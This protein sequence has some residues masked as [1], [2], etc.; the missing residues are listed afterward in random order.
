MD[1]AAQTISDGRYTYRY[2]ADG[3]TI[4]VT[5]PNGASYYCTYHSEGG[6]GAAGW[7]GDYDTNTYVDGGILVSVIEDAKQ[8]E[9]AGGPDVKLILIG[10]LLCGLGIY[11]WVAPHSVWQGKHGW[12][13]KD[14]EPSDLAI[15]VIKAMGI[16][17]I[18]AG[19]V[20][21]IFSF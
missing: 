15:G 8:K 14:A 16:I 3:Q 11:Q 13:Y 19:V 7:N 20:V 12:A 2:S 4:T 18:I 21:I 6:L 10:L 9:E 5:Y 17:E 1:S